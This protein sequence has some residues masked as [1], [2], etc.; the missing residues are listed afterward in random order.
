MN[1]FYKSYC[2]PY[3]EIITNGHIYICNFDRYHYNG[4]DVRFTEHLDDA[5]FY[6]TLDL[7][8]LLRYLNMK[9]RNGVPKDLIETEPKNINW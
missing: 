4:I 1:K 8:L 3:G 5:G 9:F 2:H 6:C 7:K